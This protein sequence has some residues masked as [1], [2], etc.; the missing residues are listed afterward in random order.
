MA[1]RT[2]P[3]KINDGLASD[4]SSIRAFEARFENEVDSALGGRIFFS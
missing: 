1:A 2:S 4:L 3:A